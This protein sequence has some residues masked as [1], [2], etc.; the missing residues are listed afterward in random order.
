[1]QTLTDTMAR[2]LGD[3]LH[4]SAR[5]ARIAQLERGDF[6]VWLHGEEQPQRF[7]AVICCTKACALAR[8][9]IEDARREPQD[10]S[11][12]FNIPH[13]PMAMLALGFR[14]SQVAHALDGFGMLIPSRE[15]RD[16]LGAVFA[17]TIFS[18][19][20]PRD[21]VLLVC[22]MG[23]RQPHMALL[24]E[25]QKITRAT[26]DLSQLLGIQGPPV[27]TRTR[28]WQDS[29]P[30]YEI[31]H[32]RIL[33][34]AARIEDRMPGLRLLGNWRDGISVADVVQNASAAAD[35]IHRLLYP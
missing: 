21:H 12:I 31:G 3:D 33:Q 15:H 16:I 7:D 5:V 30:Q 8:I 1:M 23:G 25:E 4:L 13:P 2:Q 24:P 29:I 17:S 20:A 35:H 19:R 34:H 10:L 22:F 9:H 32:G 18:E 11:P 26:S 28:V 6:H 14:R 27:Y